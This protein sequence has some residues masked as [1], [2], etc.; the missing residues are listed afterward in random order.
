MKNQRQRSAAFLVAGLAVAL[1]AGLVMYPAQHLSAQPQDA[2]ASK[3]SDREREHI[4]ALGTFVGTLDLYLDVAALRDRKPS[5]SG[6]TNAGVNHAVGEAY[7]V[8]KNQ[9]GQLWLVA[10]K[11]IVAAHRTAVE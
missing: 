2:V 8:F 10:P 1:F 11:A 7:L 3:Q 9:E 5:V 6:V 4:E